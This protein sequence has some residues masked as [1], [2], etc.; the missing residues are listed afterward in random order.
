MAEDEAGIAQGQVTRTCRAVNRIWLSY[1]KC[2]KMLDGF[3]QKYTAGREK[4]AEAGR[5]AGGT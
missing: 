4:R 2:P 5:P 1:Q 3:E